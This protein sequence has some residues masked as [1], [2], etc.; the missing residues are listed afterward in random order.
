MSATCV[1][2]AYHDVGVRCLSVLIEKGLDVRLVATHRDDPGEN[3]FF[4]SVEQLARRHQPVFSR[5]AW[6]R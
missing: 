1:V 5:T 4:A 3:V 6:T 2:F